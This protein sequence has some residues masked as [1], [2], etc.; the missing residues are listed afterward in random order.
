MKIIG[1]SIYSH[2]QRSKSLRD[3]LGH[4]VLI[5]INIL[6]NILPGLSIDQQGKYY[7]TAGEDGLVIQWDLEANAFA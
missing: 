5:I 3:P 6:Y 7:Y 2:T 4:S 1:P